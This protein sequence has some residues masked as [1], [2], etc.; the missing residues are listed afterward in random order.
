MTQILISIKR[1]LLLSLVAST[2]M[3]LSSLWARRLKNQKVMWLCMS[4]RRPRE[5]VWSPGTWV[6]TVGLPVYT[7]K[8]TW[9]TRKSIKCFSLL[10]HLF[11][12]TLLKQAG[13]CCS[14]LQCHSEGQVEG[15]SLV[16]GLIGPQGV[17][18][19]L[20]NPK[21]I[22]VLINIIKKLWQERI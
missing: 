12:T 1:I 6:T 10:R 13:H 9:V 21:I 18:Y 22:H 19:H 3:L 14:R 15:S 5:D 11:S 7:G 2:F 20:K 4:L 8:W 17:N 16:P